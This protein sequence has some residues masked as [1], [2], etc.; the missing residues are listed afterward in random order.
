MADADVLNIETMVQDIT[1]HIDKASMI[2]EIQLA[3]S[4]QKTVVDLETLIQQMRTAGATDDVIREVL[5]RALET[6]GRIF[7]GL[8]SQFRATGD[9][10]VAQMSNIGS[11][12]EMSSAGLTE[13]QWQTAGNKICDD[14]KGRS[15]DTKTWQ[16]WETVG[17][18]AT[19]WSVCGTH[20]KCTLV[21]TG[22]AIS[23]IK[24]QNLAYN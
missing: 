23:P 18:P 8:R 11:A 17:L 14:C 22:T 24:V 5:Q 2:I 19:G 4:V 10:G 12:Y 3:G 1:E 20:C 16:E 13:Y 7:G 9:F 15:G 6:G 21:P